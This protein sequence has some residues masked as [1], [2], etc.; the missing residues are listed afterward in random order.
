MTITDRIRFNNHDRAGATMSRE[1]LKRLRAS[2]ALI[3]GVEACIENHM[4]FSNV[5]RMRLSTLKKMLSRATIYEEMELHR[6]DC[7]ASHGNIDNYYFVAKKLTEFAKEQIKPEP[8]ISGRDIIAAGLK[9]GPVFGEIL[10]EIYD[11]QLEEK[12]VTREDALKHLQI[13]LG[14]HNHH[15]H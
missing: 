7:L 2:N 4:N 1:L 10:S 14:K 13:I 12:I 3:D 9:P 8:L 15:E 6:I 5:T 11:L